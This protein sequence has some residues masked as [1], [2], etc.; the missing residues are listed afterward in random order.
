LENTKNGDN[1]VYKSGGGITLDSI[2][3]DEYNEMIE[4]V[5]I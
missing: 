5:Y 3:Q 2:L 4:K 1:L